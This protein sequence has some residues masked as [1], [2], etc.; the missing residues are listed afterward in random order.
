[1][2]ERHEKITLDN[3]STI[4][5]NAPNT[6]DKLQSISGPSD[7]I[8]S[9][10]EEYMTMEES[11][12]VTGGT[13]F[14]GSYVVE[15]LV[16]KGYLVCVTDNREKGALLLPAKSGKRS[17][18]M[19]IYTKNSVQAMS[20]DAYDH[21]IHLAAWSNVR[22]SM[23]LPM[24]LYDNNVMATAKIVDMVLRTS[25]PEYSRR[26]KSVVFASSSAV[27]SPESHYGV[28]KAASEMMMTVLDS[29][30]EASVAS[31]RFA[32][33]YG[34]R[35]NPSNGTLIAKFIDCIS[36]GNRPQIFGAGNQTRDYIH[37][38]DV[39]SAI[40]MSMEYNL[41]GV[42]NVCTGMEASVAYIHT[43]IRSV[44]EEMGLV[45]P[46]GEL[47]DA[48]PGDKQSV[49]MVPAPELLEAGWQ[50]HICLGDDIKRQIMWQKKMAGSWDDNHYIDGSLA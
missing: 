19:V 2:A 31:L 6:A 11:V 49:K 47:V 35:Q 15:L 1:M 44:A 26:P 16:E 4:L 30:V 21:I 14:I 22:E 27:E 33:V 12:L 34:A 24:K 9:I 38:M 23:Q 25:N 18:M 13:G 39:A 10:N 32:N 20:M 45:L 43:K 28:S 7:E 3:R 8:K 46:V 5:R 50:P 48:K 17:S 42:M 29:Q 40:V 36:T 37:A 41:S